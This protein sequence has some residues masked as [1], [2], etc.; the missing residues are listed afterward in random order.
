MAPASCCS[1]WHLG[2]RRTSATDFST[3]ALD[4]VRAHLGR[5]PN[6][7]VELHER[8]AD[9]FSGFTP[10]SFDTIVLNSVVQ[11]FPSVPYLTAV[12]DGAIKLLAPGG[13]VFVG[14]VR[15]LDLLQ[16]FHTSVELYL[17]ADTMPGAEV[18]ERIKRRVGQEDE[19]VIEPAFF[20]AI[21]R[22]WPEVEAVEVQLRR[23]AK[24][25]ELTA[26][27]YDAVLQTAGAPAR[28]AGASA[29][30]WGAV[31]SLPA[32][33]SL[34]EGG[35]DRLH[36]R[37]V[38][39]LR[40]AGDL[41]AAALL[42]AAE[43]PATCRLLKALVAARAPLI[44]P[45]AVWRLGEQHGF[46]VRIG[47]S[48]APEAFDAFFEKAD[49][50]APYRAVNWGAA[51]A[52]VKPLTEFATRPLE[53]ERRRTLVGEMREFLR[54]RLP[55][56]MVPA[57]LVVLDALPLT[58][59]GKIDREAL[60]AADQTR[61]DFTS[62]FVAPR[63]VLEVTIA[64]VWQEVLGLDKVGIGDHFFDL[65]GHS[66][67]LVRLHGR[68]TAVLDVELSLTDLFEHTTV[69][70]LARHL[71]EGGRIGSSPAAVD[72]WSARLRATF[73]GPQGAFD[74]ST[75]G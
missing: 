22:L 35:L 56:Y 1:A 63:T 15:N 74:A 53:R 67:L 21:A 30:E 52:A 50:A 9:D 48:A 14:D 31:G 17:A 5:S 62:R 60:R 8:M 28:P 34:L 44:D 71:T 68:L 57:D 47:Y 18:R 11:Y 40:I 27:R 41:Q 37:G 72:S 61:S 65:G 20:T 70:A 4:H 73:D 39:N 69:Q 36:V 10:H 45:E 54:G 7:A 59:N 26:Y 42:N 25:N 75:G 38:P 66:L 3:A 16:A 2:A 49:A 6:A 64:R 12:L 24:R 32:L 55:D 13:R 29:V 46:V 51:A 43:P 23:G 19:L 58:P 33:G